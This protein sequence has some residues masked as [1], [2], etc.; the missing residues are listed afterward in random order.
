MQ[1]T[2]SIQKQIAHFINFHSLPHSSLSNSIE[3]IVTTKN[4]QEDIRHIMTLLK[5]DYSIMSYT[6]DTSVDTFLKSL[7][8]ALSQGKIVF[9]A[10]N[11]FS[12]NPVI[13]D[14]LMQ[15]RKN[16]QFTVRLNNGLGEDLL[17]TKI[18]PNAHIFIAFHGEDN[19]K[20]RQSMYEL[21]NHVL[22]FEK[23]KKI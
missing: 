19:T 12:L 8:Q 18:S 13:F 7:S 6:K 17:Q 9:I 20:N 1:I 15:L 3:G 21:A 5:K 23:A 14:Q 4:I 22:T 11:S 2:L 10:I 16:N